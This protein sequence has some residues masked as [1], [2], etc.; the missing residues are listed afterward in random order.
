[1]LV[2]LNS[3]GLFPTWLGRAF[4]SAR[5]SAGGVRAAVGRSGFETMRLGRWA[6][7]LLVALARLRVPVVLRTL[8]AMQ[9]ALAGTIE[10]D[11][12]DVRRLSRLELARRLAVV[13]T[14]RLPIGSLP[15]RSVVELGRYP[16]S[17]WLGALRSRDRHVVDWAMAAVGAAHLA[18]RDYSML[19]DGE[20]QRIMIA[21]AL[22]QEPVVMLL[23]TI[24][25]PTKPLTVFP[26]GSA[27]P[28][29]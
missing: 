2:W 18:A 29:A 6:G 9:P 11:G 21:R 23:A 25:D 5:A 17:G 14:D 10:V 8:A 1:M 24:Y 26:E 16:Y 28:V 4:F 27:T 22:A 12:C 15:A 3:G 20:R 13:L 19:S 7:A